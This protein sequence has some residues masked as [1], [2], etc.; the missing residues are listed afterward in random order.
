MI[1]QRRAARRYRDTVIV[2]DPN[3]QLREARERARKPRKQDS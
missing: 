1:E 2:V 3:Q